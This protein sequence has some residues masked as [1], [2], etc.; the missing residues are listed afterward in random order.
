LAKLYSLLVFDALQ[1]YSYDAEVAGLT[2]SLNNVQ[3]GLQ[4]DNIIGSDMTFYKLWVRGYDHKLPVLLQA[5]ADKMANLQIE[6]ER[7]ALVKD[8]VYCT[9]NV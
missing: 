1:E 2:Y 5:V 4:V 3:A 7:F 6:P 8:M 9:D